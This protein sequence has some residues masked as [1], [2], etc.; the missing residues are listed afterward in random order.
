MDRKTISIVGASGYAGGEFLRLA[1][2]HPYLEVKQVTSRRFAGEPVHFVHPNLRGRTNLK[3][4][5][6]EKLEPADILVLALPHGVFAREFDRYSALAP[7]LVDLSADFRLKDP[8][9]YRRYY[10]EHPRPD[11]LGRFVYAVP[12]LHREALKEADWIAGAGCNATATLLGLYPLLKA[13]VL[14]PT[15]IFVTLLISTSAGGAEASPAS[16]HPERAGS[17]RVY[18]PTGHRHTAEVVENLPGR[19][20][21]HLTAIA[22]DRV[23]GILMTAQCFVQD[24]WS[25]RDVW[26]AYREAY[27][28]EPFVRIV[29][30]KKGIHRYPDPRFV[31]GTNYADIGFELEEDTGRLVVMVAIDNLVKGT[32]GHALQALNIRM[33]WPETLGLDF[34]GL[35]P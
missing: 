26:Q 13:G 5:L 4:V 29:K 6:P 24:G 14:K 33:G 11:L 31:Q 21:V 1:L 30:Q 35:H 27:A 34:P 8:E 25:E 23:R 18:K 10:G 12:E 2:S 17:I 20:E 22:T 32:A 16:H 9:L 7:V 3:F 28:G 15:P 19:P